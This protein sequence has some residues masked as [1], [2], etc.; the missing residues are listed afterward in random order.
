MRLKRTFAAL[1]EPRETLAA[2]LREM[3]VY[4][5][6]H[7]PLVQLLTTPG[8]QERH[9]EAMAAAA[10]MPI[11]H[12]PGT[13]LSEILEAG[14]LEHTSSFEDICIQVGCPSE[15]PWV[16]R[17]IQEDAAATRPCPPARCPPARCC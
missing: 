14:L 5:R 4:M 12:Q 10:G 3:E 7:L 17:E 1:P 13:T 15:L 9:W 11:P 6:D 16:P 8:M 2:A